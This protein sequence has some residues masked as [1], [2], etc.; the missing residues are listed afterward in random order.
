M[1]RDRRGSIGRSPT[2]TGGRAAGARLLHRGGEAVAPEDGAVVTDEPPLP[3]EA[4]TVLG[5]SPN[6]QSPLAVPGCASSARRITFGCP[7]RE[8]RREAE[9]TSAFAVGWLLGV[10]AATI[11]G[12]RIASGK[13]RSV[14]LWALLGCAFGL[15]PVVILALLP[16]KA[17]PSERAY[18][19]PPARSP[20]PLYREAAPPA[21]RA[22]ARQKWPR[23]RRLRLPSLRR[24][25]TYGSE[26]ISDSATE[27][28]RQWTTID[29]ASI[30]RRSG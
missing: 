1:T 9:T 18:V 27:T 25:H 5:S 7:L 17:E 20:H 3:V 19:D 2:L 15:I 12:A 29:R 16:K 13:K 24:D 26:R 30:E 14:L 22:R 21:Q 8:N 28:L 6:V 23:R 10:L 4:D 11:A